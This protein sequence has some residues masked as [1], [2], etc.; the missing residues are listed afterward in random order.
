MIGKASDPG[1]CGRNN[2]LFME[3]VLWIVSNK[4]LWHRIPPQFGKWNAT[5]MRFR[6]WT[7]S[8]FWRFL[9]QDGVNDP[10]LLRMLTDIADY[11]DLYTKRREQRLIRR[12]YKKLY[13]GEAATFKCADGELG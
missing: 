6:R 13:T 2:R 1:A 11:A 7:E 4:G 9:V 3:A 12:N 5:Y 10:E 8:N